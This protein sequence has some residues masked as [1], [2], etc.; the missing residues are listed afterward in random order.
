MDNMGKEI[1][2]KGDRVQ[3]ERIYFNTE[4]HRGTFEEMDSNGDY[5]IK[6]DD[7]QENRAYNPN[8]VKKEDK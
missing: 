8:R 1:L 6:R 3:V 7:L 5:I 4:P 2:K